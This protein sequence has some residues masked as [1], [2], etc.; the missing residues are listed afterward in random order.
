MRTALEINALLRTTP[1]L[2]DEGYTRHWIQEAQ[3]KEGIRK[4]TRGVFISEKDFQELKPWEGYTVQVLT[5]YK[6]SPG[7][8]FSHQ[9][10]A[11]LLDL[12]LLPMAR[13]RVHI[14]CRPDSRGSHSGVVKHPRLSDE[15]ALAVAPC[16][17]RV[18]D[19][20][21]SL[22]DCAQV[23]TRREACV[24]ADSALS[25]QLIS[26]EELQAAMASYEGRNYRKVQGVASSLTALSESPGETLVRLLLEEMGLAYIQQY[27]VG[28][29]RADFYLP[30]YDAFLEFDGDIKYTDYGSYEGVLQAERRRERDFLN[31]GARIFR[32]SWEVVYRRPEVFKA[33]LRAF[34]R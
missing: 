8:V 27:R 4:L 22:I 11:A 26:R 28:A 25:Q 5:R 30:E 10:A 18:T 24:A 23:L 14:Y 1:E 3:R 20:A 9:S 13:R 34:L 12:A 17:A 2:L 15:T 7:T 32:T 6:V 21:T 29:Y 33:Q 31:S 16:G 19:V